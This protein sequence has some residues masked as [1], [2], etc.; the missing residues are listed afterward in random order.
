[1]CCAACQAHACARLLVGSPMLLS[2][3]AAQLLCMLH[4]LWSCP[5]QD[6]NDSMLSHLKL[7]FNTSERNDEAVLGA[8]PST[9]RRRVLRYLYLDVLQ[10]SQLFDGARQRFLDALLAAAR[11]EVYLPNVSGAGL[12]YAKL[13]CLHNVASKRPCPGA[14]SDA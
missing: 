11:V 1:M 3:S 4:L 7:H 13:R 8:Y 5:A 10:S 12:L 2:C 14:P 6:L 9:I